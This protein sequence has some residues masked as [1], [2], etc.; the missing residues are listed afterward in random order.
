MSDYLEA[1]QAAETH[2]ELVEIVGKYLSQLAD[3]SGEGDYRLDWDETYA[4]TAERLDDDTMRAAEDR[5]WEIE[6]SEECDPDED[7]FSLEELYA[8]AETVDA[9]AIV[10]RGIVRAVGW[11]RDEVQRCWESPTRP[12]LIVVADYVERE[13][14]AAQAR[15][16]PWNEEMTLED[17]SN[18]LG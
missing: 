8:W 12:E 9:S 11:D 6:G 14:G 1:I 5:Y 16:H 2:T 17:M 7:D 4:E 18:S 3:E 10:A 13:I 15:Q